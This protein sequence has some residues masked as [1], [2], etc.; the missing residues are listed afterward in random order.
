MNWT[1]GNPAVLDKSCHKKIDDIS[2]KIRF[3]NCHVYIYIYPKKRKRRRQ[4]SNL[5]ITIF[6]RSTLPKTNIAENRSS[7][8]EGSLPTI[9]FQGRAVSFRGRKLDLPPRAP[10]PQPILTLRCAS[11]NW[12]RRWTHLLPKFS[13]EWNLGC[14]VARLLNAFVNAIQMSLI[15]NHKQVWSLSKIKSNNDYLPPCPLQEWNPGLRYAVEVGTVRVGWWQGKIT[16]LQLQFQANPNIH[17]NVAQV[18]ACQPSSHAG[19][20]S[21]PF[22]TIDWNTKRGWKLLPLKQKT[23]STWWTKY[24]LKEKTLRKSKFVRDVKSCKSSSKCQGQVR[25]EC[26]YANRNQD[27]TPTALTRK[28]SWSPRNQSNQSRSQVPK[29]KSEWFRVCW[30]LSTTPF[31]ILLTLQ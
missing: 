13:W 4:I 16:S 8:K 18:Q 29:R 23:K 30:F 28:Q 7:Q 20:G 31:F 5:E 14:M 11:Q 1:S 10:R 17:S 15:A 24:I 19:V 3:Q 25:V 12:G 2:C 9:H 22:K 26:L 27:S 21:A 6:S